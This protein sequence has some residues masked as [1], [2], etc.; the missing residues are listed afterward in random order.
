MTGQIQKYNVLRGF[1]FVLQDFRTR[2]FFHINDWKGD[3]A[4]VIGMR[5]SYDV[6][7]PSKPNDLRMLPQAVHIVPLEG[8]DAPKAGA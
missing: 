5:V 6:I 4:P 7:P 2:L 8:S 1:G 3:V